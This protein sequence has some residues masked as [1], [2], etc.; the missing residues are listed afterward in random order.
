MSIK[1]PFENP[2]LLQKK[3]PKPEKI[4]GAK[5][6]RDAFIESLDKELSAMEKSGR[7]S[8]KQAEEK[9]KAAALIETGFSDDPAYDALLFL[10]AGIAEEKELIE[11]FDKKNAEKELAT[12]ESTPVDSSVADF[13]GT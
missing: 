11:I 12:P 7:I 6:P 13:E 10:R 8:A 4:E 1:N 3:T 5:N 9:R 2:T